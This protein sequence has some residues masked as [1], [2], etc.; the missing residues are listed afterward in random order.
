MVNRRSAELGHQSGPLTAADHYGPGLLNDTNNSYYTKPVVRD[1]LGGLT[2]SLNY[3]GQEETNPLA[4][5]QV[6]Q[7]YGG[8]IIL[9]AMRMWRSSLSRG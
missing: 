5:I 9:S 7:G 2:R 4:Y 6:Q 8:A 3:V 1:P